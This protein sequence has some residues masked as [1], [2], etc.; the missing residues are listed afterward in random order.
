MKSETF[1]KGSLPLIE[2]HCEARDPQYAFKILNSLIEIIVDQHSRKYESNQKALNVLIV[3]LREK[4]KT[5]E[6]T[7]DAQIQHLKEIQNS[8]SDG[9]QS[10][11]EYKKDLR[12]LQASPITPV[13]LLYFQSS[14]LNE[15]RFISD[16]NQ[17]QVN[18]QVAIEKNQATIIAYQDL[19]VNIE[20]R[21]TLSKMTRV[22]KPIKIPESPIKPIKILI[23]ISGAIIGFILM[24]S[25]VSLHGALTR[26]DR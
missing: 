26:K 3:N 4:I 5:T 12:K 8:L 9:K 24:I 10:I 1:E 25:F 20:R 23:M 11:D 19:I 16:L 17:V 18:L 13:E 14:S 2:I 7:I 15:G 6:K 21:I 22:I